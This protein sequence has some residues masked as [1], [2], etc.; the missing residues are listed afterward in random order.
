MQSCQTGSLIFKK[1]MKNDI[2]QVVENI[3]K[4][5]MEIILYKY[6]HKLN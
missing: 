6:N 2:F 5:T 3:T 4:S 1:L